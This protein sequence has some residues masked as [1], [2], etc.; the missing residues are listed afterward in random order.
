MKTKFMTN[1]ASV[2][3]LKN[4][5]IALLLMA[6]F[7]A[8]AEEDKELECLTKN[9]YFEA[10]G[11]GFVGE[12]AVALVTLNRVASKTYPDTICEVV[13]QPKQFSWAN[14]LTI[15]KPRDEAAWLQSREVA[16]Y[17]MAGYTV[18]SEVEDDELV[19]HYHAVQV[20]PYWARD[21]DLIGR[22]GNHLFYKM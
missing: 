5:V 21:M 12:M 22:I 10:R 18:F 8:Q 1:G 19:M 20:E 4:L 11:E 3:I 7:S 2:H 17:I 16:R 6:S 14:D 13:Y 15:T 9:L